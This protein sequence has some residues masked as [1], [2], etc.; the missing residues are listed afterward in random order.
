MF[1]FSIKFWIDSF[2]S[3]IVSLLKTLP[4]PLQGSIIS[5]ELS[6]MIFI[7]VLLHVICHFLRPLLRFFLLC[8]LRSLAIN[9]FWHSF[10]HCYSVWGFPELFDSV[11]IF[12]QFGGN[13]MSLSPQIF[14][15]WLIIFLLFFWDFKYTFWYYST[16][17]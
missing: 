14:F 12:Q 7:R 6:A 4:H 8:C 15:S 17:T 16:D 3:F 9:V 2:L 5:D 10:L 1:S 13:F 11:N